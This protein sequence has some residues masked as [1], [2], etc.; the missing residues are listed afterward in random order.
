[1]SLKTQILC[2][3]RLFLFKKTV[4]EFGNAQHFAGCGCSLRLF[5]DSLHRTQSAACRIYEIQDYI[6]ERPDFFFR[7]V[8][9]HSKFLVFRTA[10]TVHPPYWQDGGSYPP[11]L[12]VTD[13]LLVPANAKPLRQQVVQQNH[14]S[15]AEEIKGH[16]RSSSAAEFSGLCPPPLSQSWGSNRKISSHAGFVACISTIT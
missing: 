7:C 5:A 3:F 11:D 8:L 13:R 2:G 9:L 10:A 15:L 4:L 14:R 6:S 16:R 12:T 1:M